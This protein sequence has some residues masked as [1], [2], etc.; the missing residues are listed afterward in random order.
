MWCRERERQYVF[1]GVTERTFGPSG[2][3]DGTSGLQVLRVDRGS[4]GRTQ[5]SRRLGIPSYSTGTWTRRPKIE[6]ITE[7]HTDT[8]VVEGRDRHRDRGR[9]LGP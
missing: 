3:L 8:G 9:D 4:S 5:R 1:P 2:S 7:R 6:T